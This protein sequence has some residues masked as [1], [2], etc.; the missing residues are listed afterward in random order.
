MNRRYGGKELA[1]VL[2]YFGLIHEVSSSTFNIMCVFH[3]DINPS[4][5]VDLNDGSFYCF[6][7]E[8]SGNALDFIKYLK[9]ELDDLQAGML[10]EK[11]LNSNEIKKLNIRYK[12]KRKTLYKD[13]IN[14]AKDFYYGLL[15]TDWYN[16]RTREEQQVLE[17]MKKRGFDEHALTVAHCKVNYDIAYPMVF[18]ILDNGRFKGWVCRTTHKNVEKKRKYLYNEGFHKRVTL[19]GEY[20]ENCIPCVC[21]GFMDYL[22]IK[23]RGGVK[24]VVALL[25]WH[26]SDEQVNLLKQKGVKTVISLLD[27]DECG[28]KGT[29]YLKKFFNVIPFEYEDGIKDAGDMT[30]EQLKKG[31][32]KARKAAKSYA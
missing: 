22:S 23:T 11:I 16:L 30:P 18:P 32:K 28:M 6:A 19:C 26:I 25:G 21:E 29:E 9:P 7:C 20:S 5:R 2:I 4:M 12:K 1:K 27:N 13:A 14:K 17:Y 3:N 24:N 8:A 31:L 10:L 15:D